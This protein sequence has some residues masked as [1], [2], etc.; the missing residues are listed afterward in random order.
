[1]ARAVANCKFELFHRIKFRTV[2]R[3]HH[4]YKSV[5]T[6]YN[7]ESLEAYIDDRA[8]AKE[9]DPYAVGIYKKTELGEKELVG[10]VP[11]ELSSLIFH[12]LN[13]NPENRITVK[14]T[15]KRK[16]EVGLVV[17]AQFNG[18]TKEKKVAMVLD[19]EISKRKKRY[20]SFL[21]LKHQVKRNYR[22][23]PE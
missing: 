22:M 13:A 8:E 4:V 6:P 2:I 3:G 21:E 19:A 23:F 20:E 5:W 12:F 17:P 1:M 10:H 7:G 11:I 15:G 18:L 9:Y 14:V 16:R